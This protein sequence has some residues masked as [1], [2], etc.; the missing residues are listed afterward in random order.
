MHIVRF[1]LSLVLGIAL[2]YGV[3]RWDRRRLHVDQ[4]ERAWNGASW[5]AA[6]YAF[7]PLSML[8]WV[9]VTR[10]QVRVWWGK[11]RLLAVGRGVVLVVAGLVAAAAIFALITGADYL[12]GWL[13]GEPE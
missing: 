5:G 1:V 11:N 6:L 13:S 7:G 4:L 12:V 8:G 10:Q 9:W 3:Q 2:T